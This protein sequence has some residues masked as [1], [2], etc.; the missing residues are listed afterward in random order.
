MTLP[1][2]ADAL[3]RI[4]LRLPGTWSAIPLNDR[5]RA[6][7]AIRELVRRQV[8]VADDRAILRDELSRHLLAALETSIEGDGQSFHVAL[9]IVPRIPIPVSVS[10]SLP[11][12]AITPAVGTSPAAV[13]AVLERGLEQTLVETWPTA[14]RFDTRESAVLR[15]HRR[16]PI[17]T[18]EGQEPLDALVA[19][20]WM[21]VP[22]TKRFVLVSCSTA[23]GSLEEVMLGFFDSLV[24]VTRWDAPA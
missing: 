19:D 8:G 4:V 16:V 24:R 3:P 5:E 9:Q 14:K 20:Y 13:M 1:E 15:L 18:P 6:R 22:G 21:T 23:F 12:Q 2:T 17:P 10:V 11:R 7:T